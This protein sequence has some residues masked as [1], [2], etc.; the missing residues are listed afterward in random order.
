MMAGIF[1]EVRE[2]KIASH[3]LIVDLLH[4]VSVNLDER[5]FPS[6]QLVEDRPQRP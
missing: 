6:K 5:V 3:Y 2:L 1:H 4:I